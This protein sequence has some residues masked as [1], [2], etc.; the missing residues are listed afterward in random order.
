[1]NDKLPTFEGIKKEITNTFH[2]LL[3]DPYIDRDKFDKETC[4]LNV[5]HNGWADF[6]YYDFA[7]L[8]SMT[9]EQRQRGYEETVKEEDELM[10]RAED[11]DDLTGNV[12]Y[13]ALV[14]ELKYL[15]ED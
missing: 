9:S 5:I 14:H 15:T 2:I 11:F 4:L 13:H 8:A 1:M 6:A 12:I 7:V 10:Q 3:T